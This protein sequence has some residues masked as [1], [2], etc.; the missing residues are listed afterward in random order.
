MDMLQGHKNILL[1]YDLC[2][3]MS[4]FSS[5]S[6]NIVNIISSK[7]LRTNSSHACSSRNLQIF[8][9]KGES[10][11]IYPMSTCTTDER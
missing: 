5:Y 3:P 4:I 10:Y 11:K 2:I 9:G 1:K 6:Q 8:L 7:F